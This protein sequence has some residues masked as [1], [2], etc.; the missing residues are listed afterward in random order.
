[1]T[2]LLSPRR[3]GDEWQIVLA[4]R[5]DDYLVLRSGLDQAAAHAACQR[6]EA[7]SQREPFFGEDAPATEWHPVSFG[8]MWW[9]VVMGT[10]IVLDRLPTEVVAGWLVA[11]QAARMAERYDPER[12]LRLAEAGLSESDADLLRRLEDTAL[13]QELTGLYPASAD[14]WPTLEESVDPNSVVN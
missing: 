6:I 10:E 2:R 5:A 14:V 4:N 13:Y 12:G 3:D 7:L 9:G 1:M 11:W 8:P